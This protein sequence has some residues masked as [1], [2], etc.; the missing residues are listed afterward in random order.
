MYQRPPQLTKENAAK[1]QQEDV[2]THYPLRQ[3]YPEELF[4]VIEDYITSFHSRAS[5]SRNDLGPQLSQQFADDMRA[6]TEPFA[7]RNMLSWE[8]SASVFWG[9]PLNKAADKS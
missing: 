5:L 9:K 1:Y 3:P 4:T 2:A 7:V 6:V 8:M